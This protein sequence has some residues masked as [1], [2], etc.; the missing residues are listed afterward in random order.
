MSAVTNMWSQLVQRRLW[1]VA[2]L[3][4]A[5]L[6]AVPFT[7]AKEPDPVEPPAAAAPATDDELAVT[8]IV[9]VADTDSAAKGRRVIGQPKN[10]FGTPKPDETEART[11]RSNDAGRRQ[12]AQTPDI[13]LPTTAGGTTAPSNPAPAPAPAP[14]PAPAPPVT[15]TPEPP[16]RQYAMHELTVRF[17]DASAGGRRTLERLQ[18]LPSAENPVL[19][20]LG[21]LEDGKTAVFLVD[22]G[23]TAVGDG[24]CRPSEDECETIRMKVGD[25]EFFDVVDESGNVTAQYQ[26]DL[27]KIHHGTTA[28][29]A[30][31]G[32][33][34]KAGARALQARVSADGPAPYRWNRDTGT[35]ERRPTELR[36]S[37]GRVA[38][39][40]P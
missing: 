22:H 19:I 13:K 23:V 18:P 9:T 24:D 17:G 1:P 2:I 29:A 39:R 31:A 8:P 10:P 33:S 25:T 12:T 32:A 4:I 38:A 11:N 5:A 3:L 20:Y 15:T 36:S 16:A 7:L 14:G 27:L 40:L 21:V 28:S 6:A 30:K 26:L 37:V 34:S 35:L